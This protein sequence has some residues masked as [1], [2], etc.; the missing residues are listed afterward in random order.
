MA[1]IATQAAVQ[2]G[3]TAQ[4]NQS[5]YTAARLSKLGRLTLVASCVA[6]WWWHH[7]YLRVLFNVFYT[8]GSLHK[9]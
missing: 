8:P 1:L 9:R 3:I 6:S 2:A 5:G 7:A 4:T